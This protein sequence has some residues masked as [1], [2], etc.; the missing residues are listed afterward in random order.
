MM[1]FAAMAFFAKSPMLIFPVLAL[2]LF[3]AV[4]VWITVRTY[5]ADKTTYDA[6]SR[7]PLEDAR[8]ETSGEVRHG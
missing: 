5:R 1:R 8:V 7:L 2:V 6:I 4:F 3:F